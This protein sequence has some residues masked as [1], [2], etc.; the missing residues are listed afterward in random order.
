VLGFLAVYIWT[1]TYFAGMINSAMNTLLVEVNEKADQVLHDVS[2]LQS[3]VSHCKKA[4]DLVE[5]QLNLEGQDR[6]RPP[7]EF[8]KAF[9]PLDGRDRAMIFYHVRRARHNNWEGNK[10]RMARTIPIFVALVELD[11]E[12]QYHRNHAE[13]GYC[14]KDQLQP[15]YRRALEHLDQAIEIR[16]KRRIEGWTRYE[17]NRALCRIELALQGDDVPPD[18][19]D[20]ILEDLQCAIECDSLLTAPGCK[21]IDALRQYPRI[22]L[23]CQSNPERIRHSPLAEILEPGPG[24]SSVEPTAETSTSEFNPAHG[25]RTDAKATRESRRKYDA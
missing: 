11:K 6:D 19:Q 15:D 7:E 12:R 21:P 23:W 13:L 24:V 9:E 16:T 14:Y 20:A 4:W 22:R 3:D 2:A 1:T 10:K 18:V 8:V 5:T 17:F 25:D